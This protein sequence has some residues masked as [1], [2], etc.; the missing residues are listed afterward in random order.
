MQHV[1]TVVPYSLLSMAPPALNKLLRFVIVDWGLLFVLIIIAATIC[2]IAL[3]WNIVNMVL[4]VFLYIVSKMWSLL[5]NRAKD[6]F[7][8]ILKLQ[9]FKVICYC[10]WNKYTINSC[11]GKLCIS[12][13]FPHVRSNL[14]PQFGSK[15]KEVCLEMCNYTNYTFKL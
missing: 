5:L 12:A 8:H 3:L 14:W 10:R 13:F 9:M 4:L 2:L 6:R 11:A 1:D 7:I 15:I